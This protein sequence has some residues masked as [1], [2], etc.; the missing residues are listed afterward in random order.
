[1]VEPGYAHIWDCCCD[2]GFLGARLLSRQVA[3][4]IHFVDIVP[5]LMKNLEDKLQ[6]FY[7]DTPS[8]WKTHCLDAA[9]LPLDNYKGRQLIIIAG[10]GGDLMSRMINNILQQHPNLKADFLLC[11]VHRQFA[12]RSQ[13]IAHDFSLKDEVLVEENQ[14]FYEVLL[15]SSISDENS[16]ISQ[17]GEKVWL[18]E[19][20]EQATVA[21]TYLEKT[22]KYYLRM[23]QGEDA[24]KVDQI[25]SAYGAVNL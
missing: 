17:V 5:G 11:P 2:H 10:V 12:L 21:K 18:S 24:K 25:I 22:M 8:A 3:E 23:R 1:M 9:N 4:T 14:R 16:N 13:L 6:Q 20:T 15:V 7:R 19:T